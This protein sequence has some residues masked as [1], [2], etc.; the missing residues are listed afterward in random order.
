MINL[1]NIEEM[2]SLDSKGQLTWMTEW[3]KMIS[4]SFQKGSNTKMPKEVSFKHTIIKYNKKF[5]QI[6]IC[7]MGGSGISGEFIQNYLSE[8]EF[9]LPVSLVRGYKLPKHFTSDSLILIISYSGNTRET[10]T[11]LYEAL[12]K[13]IPVILV[14]SGGLCFELSEKAKLPIIALP[15][16]FEPRAAFPVLL[17]RVCF[18]L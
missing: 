9:N 10:L 15:K 2:K 1:D 16:G 3:P 17:S 5:N 13:S 12:N 4:E 18:P 6:G 8:T 7:G 11:C 14:S